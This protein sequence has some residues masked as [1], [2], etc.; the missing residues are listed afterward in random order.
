VFTGLIEDVGT[1]ERAS[2]TAT[3][4][5]LRVRSHCR[6][7]ALGE[8]IAL[9]GACLTVRES[10]PEWFVVAAAEM[11]LSRTTIGG[12]LPGR[13]VNVERA[14]RADARFGG[15]FVQGHVDGVATVRSSERRGD[16]QYVQLALPDDVAELTVPHGSIAVDG[17]SLTVNQGPTDGWIEVA[18][19]EFT[20]RHTTL[21]EL[22]E[23]DL[24]HVEGD[25]IGKHVRQLLLAH[26][27]LA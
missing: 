12:W 27:A 16:T 10:G 5:E 13:R 24:V 21:G 2:V 6:D 1:V 26:K 22:A 7:L 3:G 14:M 20:L 4:R 9:N 25:V 18:L 17:V 23:G 15:H 11:T 8:S 19:I